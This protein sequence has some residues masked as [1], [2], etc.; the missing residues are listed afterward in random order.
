MQRE[1]PQIDLVQSERAPVTREAAITI[2]LLQNILGGGALTLALWIVISAAVGEPMAEDIFYWC[3]PIGLLASAI[4][5]ILRFFGDEWG[6]YMA[7]Y[8]AGQRSRDAE[9]DALQIRLRA[10]L[11]NYSAVERLRQTEQDKRTLRN[12][13]TLVDRHFSGEPTQR[14]KVPLAVMGQEEWNRAVRFL[15]AARVMDASCQVILPTYEE[16]QEKIT[17]LAQHYAKYGNGFTPAN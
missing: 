10:Q 14:A 13:R 3:L 12:A 1:H 4:V 5:T 15:K 6:L 16:S 7:A 11:T 9:I 2:P 17:A 8:R